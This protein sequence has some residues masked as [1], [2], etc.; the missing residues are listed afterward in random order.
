MLSTAILY[1][2]VI[3]SLILLLGPQE[4]QGS[5]ALEDGARELRR[6]PGEFIV[7]VMNQCPGGLARLPLESVW[8]VTIGDCSSAGATGE[9]DCPYWEHGQ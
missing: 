2:A 1:P 4:G 5:F 9:S 8:I 3:L 6:G 7:C